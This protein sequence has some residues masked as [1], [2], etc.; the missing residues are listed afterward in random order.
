MP[1]GT[2]LAGVCEQLNDRVGFQLLRA[3]VS[4]RTMHPVIDSVTHIWRRDSGI[5][6]NPN[7][8][9]DQA[10]DQWQ[11]SPIRSLV[12]SQDQRTQRTRLDRDEAAFA[13]PLFKEFRDLGATEYVARLIGFGHEGAHDHRSGMVSTWL[14]DRPGGFLDAEA[15]IL[16]RLMPRL[17]LSVKSTLGHEISTNLLE[18][19][20]GHDAGR[21]I[22]DGAFRRGTFRTIPAA[23]FFADLRG[24]TTLSDRLET[25]A[26]ASL[27]NDCFDAMVEPVTRRGGEVLKYMGDGV[28]AVFDREGRNED[29]LCE[30]ALDAAHEAITAVAS[31]GEPDTGKAMMLDV[32]L[33]LGDVLYGNVGTVDRLDFTVIGPAVN[34]ASRIEGLCDQLGHALLT[35]P[36]FARA[37]ARCGRRLRSLGRHHLRGVDTDQELFTIDIG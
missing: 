1:I 8:F 3:N 21:R 26:V 7:A 29:D 36:S 25:E 11:N 34:E 9:A 14:T 37:S 4:T 32:A 5:D 2:M 6:V 16:E 10:G 17:A 23:I 19:Y 18:T 24:F 28:L 35:S 22:L 15:L 13:F 30:G 33:H 12:E 27:L 20:V 31:I